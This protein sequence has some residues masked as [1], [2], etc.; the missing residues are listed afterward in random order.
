M[1]TTKT[2]KKN[3]KENE[4]ENEK[5]NE[6]ENEKEK[7]E[8]KDNESSTTGKI[9][10]VFGRIAD[11]TLT[12]F[13]EKEKNEKSD[14]KKKEREEIEESKKLI[15]EM[16]KK[17]EEMEKKNK[18]IEEKIKKMEEKE[19]QNKQRKNDGINEWN[20]EK[21]KLINSLLNNIDKDSIKNIIKKDY[22]SLEKDILIELDKKLND[23]LKDN[24]IIQKKYD[25][26]YKLIKD[27]IPEIKSFNFILVGFTGVG[28]SCLTNA[29]LKKD[30]AKEGDTI[31]P[32]TNNIESFSNEKQGITIYDTIGIESTNI[33][34][35]LS[36]IKE[37]I[38]KTFND[39]LEYHPEKSLHGILYCINNGS[40]S[41]RIEDGEI[42]FIQ[43]LN[44]LYYENDILIIVFTQ[45]TNAKTDE[46]KEQLRKAL[47]NDKIEIVDVLAKDIK[48]KLG[49]QEILIEAYG[50]DELRELMKKKCKDKL[51][52]CNL[53]QI[54]MKKIKQ[55]Y[56][57]IINESFEEIKGKLKSHIFENTLQEEC[58]MIVKKL[59]GNLNLDFN[60]LDDIFSKYSDKE[61]LDE[62][63]NKF[64]GL[65]KGIFIE[66][67][68][69]LF[70]LIN[71][72]YNN[73]L[74][75]VNLMEIINKKFNDYFKLN[76]TKYIKN[77]YFEK[78]SFICIEKLKE[79]IRELIS[80]NIKDKDIDELVNSNVNNLLNKD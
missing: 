3:E 42:K 46:K 22:E 66:E 30:L 78:S 24:I 39:N 54:V 62:I 45:S 12:F 71:E 21:E 43:E 56:D 63:K 70:N 4:K 8:K 16:K 75:N 37:K 2:E 23:E 20:I 29:I 80:Q 15:E 67:L 27:D 50:I 73:M 79:F 72:K 61:K 5:K 17:N 60:N 25:S 49:K 68:S 53:K 52:K 47:N 18:E 48:M 51:F 77:L 38:E 58:D 74:P 14:D 19:E 35:S 31:K 40:S 34:R 10:D 6:K 64:L 26:I 36:K 13:I 1:E 9:I 57:E 28:K 59:I 33:E 32:E 41:N 11:K 55:K 69:G 65:N 7:K 44:K 76:F